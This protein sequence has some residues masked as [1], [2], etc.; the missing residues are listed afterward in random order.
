MTGARAHRGFTLLEILFVL[1]I[2]GFMVALVAP[3]L[4]ARINAYDRQYKVRA[5]EDSFRQLPRRVRLLGSAL[6]LEKA[7]ETGALADGRSALE[8]PQGWM[9]AAEPSF[10][11]SPIGACSGSDFTL[12]DADGDVLARYHVEE[13]TCALQPV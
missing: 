9:L 4:G 11:I 2:M 5:F 8:I 6:E 3:R 10:I 12:I 7:L 13:I 1:A